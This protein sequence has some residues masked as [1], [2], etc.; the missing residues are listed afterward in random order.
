MAATAM[1]ATLHDGATEDHDSVT[2]VYE[3]TG[4]R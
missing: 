3:D 1:K 2:D 4:N